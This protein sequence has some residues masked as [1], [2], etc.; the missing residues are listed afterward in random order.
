ME[1]K[2]PQ[3]KGTGVSK[4][5]TIFATKPVFKLAGVL[6]T[7]LTLVV[8]IVL[9]FQTE[10]AGKAGEVMLLEIMGE[11]EVSAGEA[12]LNWELASNG[13]YIKE[14][15]RLRTGE[16]GSVTLLFFEG[17]RTTLGPGTDLVLTNL[18]GEGK[19]GLNVTL[20]QLAGETFHS[21][22]PFRNT[23]S[24]F[25]VHTQAGV[26][27]VHGTTFQVAVQQGGGT[28]FSVSKGQ[29]LVT[30]NNQGIML[31]AGQAATVQADETLGDP[32]YQFSLKGVVTDIS[33]ET[34]T[35]NGV[36]FQ[37]TEDTNIKDNPQVDSFVLVDGH[38]LEDGTWVADM[39]KEFK[40]KDETASFTG[41]VESMGESWVI[42]GIT[43]L[44]DGDTQVDEGIIEGAPV[45][46]KFVVLENGD[47]LA[48]EI[49]SLAE[50]EDPTPTPTSSS[51]PT[52]TVT[53]TLTSTLT[54]T[55]T[56]TLPITPTATITSTA[57]VTDCVGANPQPKGQSLADEYGVSYEEIMG[58]FCQGFGFGEI[59]QAYAL[60]L[61]TGIPVEEIF[62][63]RNSGMGWGEIKAAIEPTKTPKP[64]NTPKPSKTPKPTKTPKPSKTPKPTKT[65]KK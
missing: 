13:H 7:S 14:G 5:K 33:G 21:I 9:G 1:T 38:I 3:A 12:G 58:W 31:S 46:V 44:V 62:E 34:W 53:A 30:S 61:E 36:S 24:S 55:P 47:W 42:S 15:Q 8:L 63:M 10:R 20:N 4:I 56:A 43:V 25:Q 2:E 48:L 19:N 16:D 22:V 54:V 57:V 65:P 41:V 18:D 52:P 32:A 23:G 40:E 49:E 26:A 50:E 35:V 27:S 28:R 29:V 6:I 17:S 51:T 39:V 37:V 60:S 45:E 59:D 64:S 11:V